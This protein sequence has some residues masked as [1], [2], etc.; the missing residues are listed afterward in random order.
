MLLFVA[1]PVSHALAQVVILNDNSDPNPDATSDG[2]YFV[3][4]GGGPVPVDAS[5]PSMAA[6]QRLNIELFGGPDLDS[7]SPVAALTDGTFK[8]ADVPGIFYD[9]FG[10][11][12]NVPG[13][14]YL[15]YGYLEQRVWTGTA[16]SY[17]DALASGTAYVASSTWYQLAGQ[18]AAP[19]FTFYGMPATIFTIPEPSSFALLGLGAL[20][21]FIRRNRNQKSSNPLPCHRSD[22]F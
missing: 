3:D 8:Y 20:A 15:W 13:V 4:V 17:A 18:T 19:A 9:E 1:A 2:L 22:P 12:W 10:R 14:P 11:E 5:Q 6:F 16:A 7:L 21:L